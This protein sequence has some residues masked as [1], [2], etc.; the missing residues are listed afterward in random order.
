MVARKLTM[1]Q[2]KTI[3]RPNH[4]NASRF[5]PRQPIS[6]GLWSPDGAKEGDASC[7]V[8]VDGGLYIVVKNRL[9]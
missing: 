1:I 9:G 4:T 6:N 8:R 5:N 7:R 2:A 3:S